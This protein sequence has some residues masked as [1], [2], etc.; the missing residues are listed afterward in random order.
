MDFR[1]P[2]DQ[3]LNPYIDFTRQ[4]NE[5]LNNFREQI[6]FNNIEQTE[7]QEDWIYYAFG[8]KKRRTWP[9]SAH[10]TPSCGEHMQVGHAF[11]CPQGAVP[12]WGFRKSIFFLLEALIA[13]LPNQRLL[14]KDGWW[15]SFNQGIEWRPVAVINCLSCQLCPGLEQGNCLPEAMWSWLTST[16]S[17]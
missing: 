12:T 10:R 17:A 6:C 4:G 14:T 8:V 1:F 16:F 2:V 9:I 13:W 15:L 5:V 7:W 11:V 3:L